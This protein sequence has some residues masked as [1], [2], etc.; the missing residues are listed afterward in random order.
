MA[1]A[2]RALQLPWVSIRSPRGAEQTWQ[3]LSSGAA[4]SALERFGRR[5]AVMLEL[6]AL[7]TFHDEPDAP[8][9]GPGPAMW[10]DAYCRFHD[11]LE[12]TTGKRMI[13]PA[14]IVSDWWFNPANPRRHPEEWL[15][16][17]VLSRSPLLG[18]TVYANASGETF[19]RR[20]P[21]VLNW[22][23][24]KGFGDTMVGIA[25][26]GRTAYA[27]PY[28]APEGWLNDS[29]AWT[30]KHTDKVGVVHYSSNA[31]ERGVYWPLSRL[32]DPNKAIASWIGH[33]I[34]H[35]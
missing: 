13:T 1:S 34:T 28:V 31:P 12:S 18:V 24:E 17:D 9:G 26:S 6:P 3:H 33:A 35:L 30:A 7:I 19:E 10:A 21:R 16:D 27:P 25:G 29:L 5:L 32:Q 8:P 14:P 4:D 22:L 15:N 11:V 2:H 23:T 20:I